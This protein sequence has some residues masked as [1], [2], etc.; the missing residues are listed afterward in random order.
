VVYEDGTGDCRE[1]TPP[2]GLTHSF[3]TGGYITRARYNTTIGSLGRRLY[4]LTNS[5][6]GTDEADIKFLSR[7]YAG[8]RKD[9]KS[10]SAIL[11]KFMFLPTL[12]MIYIVHI[13]KIVPIHS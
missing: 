13:L 2:Y 6:D 8:L 5:T 10:Q 4:E 9:E 11:T 7:Y 1:G 3:P 12:V